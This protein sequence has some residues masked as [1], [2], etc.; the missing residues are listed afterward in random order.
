MSESE[1][2]VEVIVSSTSSAGSE[3]G[4]SDGFS[5]DSSS[6][7]QVSPQDVALCE[8]VWKDVKWMKCALRRLW[9]KSV[10]LAEAV[11]AIHGILDDLTYK[12]Q[13]Y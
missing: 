8:V 9:R 11:E 5:W 2:D 7:R 3:D 1:Q 12:V 6:S 4:S 13:A 10:E